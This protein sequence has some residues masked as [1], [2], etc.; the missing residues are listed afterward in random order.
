[1][2]FGTAPLNREKIVRIHLD[3]RRIFP[4]KHNMDSYLFMSCRVRM[5]GDPGTAY[6]RVRRGEREE[7]RK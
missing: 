3:K 4:R 1:M 6:D 5:M 2:D 7:R